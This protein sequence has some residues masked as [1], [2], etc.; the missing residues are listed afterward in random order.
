[1][2]LATLITHSA[3]SQ[4]PDNERSGV[5]VT[6]VRKGYARPKQIFTATFHSGVSPCFTLLLLQMTATLTIDVSYYTGQG[7]HVAI[8]LHCKEHDLLCWVVSQILLATGQSV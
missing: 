2:C 4:L 8:A 3:T 5:L 1:M 7:T 6:E